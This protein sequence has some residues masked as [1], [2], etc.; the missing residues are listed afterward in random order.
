[1][2]PEA[3]FQKQITARTAG[4][5]VTFSFEA[6]Y[7]AVVSAGFDFYAELFTIEFKNQLVAV[8]GIFETDFQAGLE[9]ATRKFAGAPLALPLIPSGLT[10]EKSV[11]KIRKTGAFSKH[12]GRVAAEG[13]GTTSASSLRKWI[14]ATKLRPVETLTSGALVLIPVGAELI[15]FLRFSG[16]PIT[17]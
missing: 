11:E 13:I 7:L 3:E 14:F 16:V 17:S 6:Q 15:V 8:I 5:G 12:I 10:T 2:R 4:T 9:I 1:M